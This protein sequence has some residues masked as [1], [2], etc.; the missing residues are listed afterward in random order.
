M[1]Q[2][3]G[4]C[5][6]SHSSFVAWPSPPG[7][8]PFLLPQLLFFFHIRLTKWTCILGG[9]PGTEVQ[10]PYAGCRA[11]HNHAYLKHPEVL[12]PYALLQPQCCTAGAGW[13][14]TGVKNGGKS[15]GTKWDTQKK[16][17]ILGSS[18]SSLPSTTP[19]SHAFILRHSCSPAWSQGDLEP[20]LEKGEFHTK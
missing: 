10:Q 14:S 15:K 9:T 18:T 8:L 12:L 3:L 13:Q 17:V 1:L 20:D 11:W 7:P 5:F 2:Y 6:E 19:H 16:H 4:S